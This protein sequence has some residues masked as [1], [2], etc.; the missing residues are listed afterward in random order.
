MLPKEL[1]DDENKFTQL[2]N[3]EF[4]QYEYYYS[5]SNLTTDTLDIKFSDVEKVVDSEYSYT[6]RLNFESEV[7]TQKR[8]EI[9]QLEMVISKYQQMSI[10]ELIRIPKVE[11]FHVDIS[12]LDD[13]TKLVEFLL[14]EGYINEFYYDYISYFYPGTLMPED[15]DFI[16]DLRIGNKKEY[17]YQLCK[18][19]SVIEEIPARLYNNGGVLNVS[20]VKYMSDHVDNID[21]SSKLDK[22]I[23]YIVSKKKKNLCLLFIRHMPIVLCC[24]KDY[25]RN[26]RVLM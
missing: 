13:K 5:Y 15:K 19:E 12:K 10:S 9:E 23:K 25:L 17:T 24:S 8:K 14:K 1:I 18:F 26:G 3:D 21:I 6:Q 7:I 4:N 22:I 20:L 11:S 2:I 16:A